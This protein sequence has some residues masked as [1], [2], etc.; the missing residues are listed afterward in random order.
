MQGKDKEIEI[1]AGLERLY[2]Y[3]Q[4]PVFIS[5]PDIEVAVLVTVLEILIL[6]QLG[7]DLHRVSLCKAI[8]PR[9]G[10]NAH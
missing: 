9:Q 5:K 10:S 7:L 8:S 6:L 3:L 4:Q 1:V 2:A